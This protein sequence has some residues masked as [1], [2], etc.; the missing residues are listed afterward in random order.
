VRAAGRRAGSYIPSAGECFAVSGSLL[1]EEIEEWPDVLFCL[2]CVPHRR[3]AVDH[4]VVAPSDPLTLENACV[5]QVGGDALGSA[6]GDADCLSDIPET[7]FA[8]FGDAEQD[9][10]VVREESPLLA[11][12]LG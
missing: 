11:R 3:V 7:G 4:V 10:S 6:F 5:H 2:G 8:V 9:L 1:D 12:L